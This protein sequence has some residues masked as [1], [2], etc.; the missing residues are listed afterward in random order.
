MKS[1]NIRITIVIA[2]SLV[3]ACS[4]P[5]SDTAVKRYTIRQFMDIVQISGGAFSA[6]ESK[7]LISTKETGIFNAEEIDI[8]SGEKKALTNSGDNAIF[9]LSY[10]PADDRML[11]TSDKGG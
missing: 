6:D 7:I 2:C 11:Y 3:I 9:A 4:K 5:A 8:K 10:F 1:S